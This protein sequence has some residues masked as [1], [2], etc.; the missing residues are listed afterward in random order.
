M[1]Q[2]FASN[3]GQR[4]S[5][6]DFVLRPPPPLEKKGKVRESEYYD[7]EIKLCTFEVYCDRMWSVYVFHASTCVVLLR[8]LTSLCT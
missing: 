4:D 6:C 7:K 1:S 2:K 8:I 5:G 3:S